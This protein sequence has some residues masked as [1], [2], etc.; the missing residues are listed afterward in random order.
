MFVGGYPQSFMDEYRRLNVSTPLSRKNR[1][2]I[3][4]LLAKYKL[5]GIGA[6]MIELYIE[7]I[8]SPVPVSDS[9]G[10]SLINNSEK[11][12]DDK[13][14]YNVEHIEQKT[15]QFE[16][17]VRKIQVLNEELY[18]YISINE[19]RLNSNPPGQ[20]IGLEDVED[21]I[22]GLREEE[23]TLIAELNTHNADI[24]IITNNQSEFHNKLSILIDEQAITEGR[25]YELVIDDICAQV[26][27]FEEGGE[28]CDR[29]MI[30]NLID[31]D[32][33]G[34][35]EPD[36]NE[37]DARTQEII[38]KL[39]T[40]SQLGIL[41]DLDTR[42]LM[43]EIVENVERY[44]DGIHTPDVIEIKKVLASCFGCMDQSINYLK[45]HP[46]IGNDDSVEGQ[47]RG[48]SS[49]FARLQADDAT[50]DVHYYEEEL[51]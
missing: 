46:D 51:L 36:I 25:L 29:A 26:P 34:I 9:L 23:N 42:I 14:R 19:T 39:N 33:D 2:D 32:L 20:P 24:V 15:T 4:K 50:D 5:I 11:F 40:E 6:K 22:F 49:R 3:K 13:I 16:E 12:Y 38:D 27:K 10:E 48:L 1:I 44:R 17:V 30:S 21:R 37:I 43:I 41:A 31:T 35:H 47:F 7:Y 28:I 18:S 8:D 45:A